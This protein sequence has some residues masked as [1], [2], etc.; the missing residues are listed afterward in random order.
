VAETVCE[1]ALAPGEPTRNFIVGMVTHPA[2]QS[3]EAGALLM[4]AEQAVMG[5]E[6]PPVQYVDGAYVSA[7]KLVEAQAQGRELIG[8]A[9]PALQKDDR[10][11]AEDF[12][13][14]VEE[15]KAICPAGKT[16]TQCS[17]LE[18]ET[19]GKVNYRFEFSTQ[20]H[21][22]ALRDRCLGKDQRHRTL[23]VGQ[24]HTALQARRQEQQT[25]AFK[26]R[27]KHRNAIEGTQSE[28]VRGHG[29]RHAR[30][31]GLAK[32]KLQNYFAGAACNVKRWLRLEAWK[33]RQ[34]MSVGAEVCG[35]G[36][37]AASSASCHAVQISFV[38]S[39]SA[40]T[41]GGEGL[42]ADSIQSAYLTTRMRST[43]LAARDGSSDTKCCTTSSAQITM[44]QSESP[45]Y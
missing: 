6:K 25:D 34:A 36:S 27:M 4:E 5:L 42:P 32:A 7:Q 40:T 33:L 26:A 11:T 43:R 19:S 3:D 20:C 16:N 35:P 17:R 12:Q 24:Y 18:Q 21:D 2:Y 38:R 1:A 45:R 14:N 28:L 37:A 41:C 44:Q 10:F 13:I 23:V 39:S 22:C 31:R 30:Y 15:R 29:L 9:Q 8:P